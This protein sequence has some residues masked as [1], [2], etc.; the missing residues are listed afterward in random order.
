MEKRVDFF[1][2]RFGNIVNFLKDRY[3][4]PEHDFVAEDYQ[5]SD[6]GRMYG[7]WVLLDGL[8]VA[9]LEYRCFLEEPVHLY[10][11]TALHETFFRID[12]DPDKWASPKLSVQSKYASEYSQYGLQ[13]AAV[14]DEMIAVQ[15]LFVPENYYIQKHL[16]V[17][18]FHEKLLAN[19]EKNAA[20][21]QEIIERELAAEQVEQ[22]EVDYGQS[23]GAGDRSRGN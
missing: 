19:A 18:E 2:M 14:G 5:N 21:E 7:W 3:V 8:R 20:K 16:S 12:L 4:I 23:I 1:S 6:F 11:V 17:T 13:M 22:E 9:S 15:N 10:A